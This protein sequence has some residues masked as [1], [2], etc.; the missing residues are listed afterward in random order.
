MLA[1]ALLVSTL[2]TGSLCH[3]VPRDYHA[4]A[5]IPD[6]PASRAHVDALMR[7][8]TFNFISMTY[9]VTR[10]ALR[11]CLVRGRDM[12]LSDDDDNGAMASASW[13]EEPHWCRLMDLM[14]ELAE[15]RA[16]PEDTWTMA[17]RCCEKVLS[18]RTRRGDGGEELVAVMGS[19][20]LGQVEGEKD[21]QWV[22]WDATEV[23]DFVQVERDGWK[24]ELPTPEPNRR[25]EVPSEE[26]L[27]Y[28]P[29]EGTGKC[30]TPSSAPTTSGE[31]PSGDGTGPEASA[32]EHSTM[33]EATSK[34]ALGSPSL[35]DEA[36]EATRNSSPTMPTSHESSTSD[37]VYPTAGVLETPHAVDEGNETTCP[38]S[39]TSIESWTMT[40]TCPATEDLETPGSLA[41]PTADMAASVGSRFVDAMWSVLIQG[42]EIQVMVSECWRA[43]KAAHRREV[44]GGESFTHL[45]MCGYWVMVRG[46]Q[47]LEF[48]KGIGT[49]VSAVF[50]R[51]VAED[52]AA[53]DDG[54]GQDVLEKAHLEA[55]R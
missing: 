50:L 19:F 54:L 9:E 17:G 7:N 21:R 12:G 34:E 15:I 33:T 41:R 1:L 43:L 26:A 16:R 46:G 51:P 8:T 5:K 20:W 37:M 38:I 4:L 13:L 10:A 25:T 31:S 11:D 6:D 44:G 30:E 35:A 48:L 27:T 36:G 24:T 2:A 45:T 3:I 52:D 42:S 18:F 40:A 47:A 28:S 49:T 55:W 23:G 22:R 32:W 29:P 39:T 14:Q 53:G